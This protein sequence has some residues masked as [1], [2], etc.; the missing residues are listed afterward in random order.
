VGKDFALLR[1][2]W[3]IATKVKQVLACRR[4]LK[5]KTMKPTIPRVGLPSCLIR[6]QREPLQRAS[7]AGIH[8]GSKC[9]EKD[10][11]TTVRRSFA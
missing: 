2:C 11:K 10:V 1:G 7:H 6:L 5:Q 9:C 8:N 4:R 3:S